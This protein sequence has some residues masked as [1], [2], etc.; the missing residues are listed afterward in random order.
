VISVKR[1][2]RRVKSDFSEELRVK[3]EERSVKS[4]E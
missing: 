3:S 1:E 4:E 2:E